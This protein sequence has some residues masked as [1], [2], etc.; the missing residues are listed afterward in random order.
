[1]LTCSTI[2]APA[3][4]RPVPLIVPVRQ[5]TVRVLHLINGEHYAG[6]ERVQDLLGQRLTEFGFEVGYACVKPDK[7][8]P[9]RK[10]QHSSLYE[11]PMGRRYDLRAAA[12]VARIVRKQGYKLIHT[13]TPR[14]ALVGSLASRLCRVPMVHH[15]HGQTLTEVNQQW[16]C[17]ISAAVERVSL[18]RASRIIAVSPTVVEYLRRQA[19]EVNRIALVPNGVPAPEDAQVRQG[20]RAGGNA[21]TLGTIA[22]FRPRK[23][24]E[25]LLG[26]VADLRA[27]GHNARLRAVGPFETKAYEAEVKARAQALG[28]EEHVDWVGFSTDVDSQLAQMDLMVLPSI[29]P[30]GLPMVV[31][32]AMASGVPPVGTRVD[33]ITDVIRHEVDGLI[34]EPKRADL[35]KQIER[36][37]RGEIDYSRLSAAALA[38]HQECY[39]DVSMARRLAEV[40]REVLC[41][42][43]ASPFRRYSQ[44][45]SP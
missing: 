13:H 14:T 28:L 37:I 20:N 38:R 10:S 3:Q 29:L 1:M 17:R 40:Y 24:T 23:G 8:G 41:V 2:D 11:T 43:R 44:I 5:D 32:E 18:H 19:V 45:D 30:E 33:G 9:R 6:A 25:M 35:V 42:E 39:S 36:V 22:L 26:A 7:F 15:V 31:L 21:W 34:C 16:L 4:P 27:A 12:A